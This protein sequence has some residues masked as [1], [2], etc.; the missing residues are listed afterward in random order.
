MIQACF[1]VNDYQSKKNGADVSQMFQ[2][3]SIEKYLSV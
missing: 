3:L 1:V 2:R